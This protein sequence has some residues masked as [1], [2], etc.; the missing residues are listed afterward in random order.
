[1]HNKEVILVL[2]PSIGLF[3]HTYLSGLASQPSLCVQPGGGRK[4]HCIQMSPRCLADSSQGRESS[5]VHLL[6][7]KGQ[8]S[9]FR[10]LCPEHTLVLPVPVLLAHVST[11]S[12]GVQKEQKFVHA[13]CH[14]GSM[15]GRVSSWGCVPPTQSL[16]ILAPLLGFCSLVYL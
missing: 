14:E 6:F 13:L 16:Q 11:P 4:G 10:D 1:M 5:S 9:L 2:L 8:A 12:P 15:P 3:G 7:L